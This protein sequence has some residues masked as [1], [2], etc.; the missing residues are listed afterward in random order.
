M[1]P[2]LKLHHIY[3]IDSIDIFINDGRLKAVINSCLSEARVP[4]CNGEK[5]GMTQKYT[6]NDVMVGFES[7]I[8]PLKL[9]TRASVRQRL[10]RPL[11][12]WH[13]LPH[14]GTSSEFQRE[15]GYIMT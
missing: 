7:N 11:R 13:T 15:K 6:L 8:S 4:K 9:G 3:I 10:S 2:S 12:S 1:V 5:K 14:W